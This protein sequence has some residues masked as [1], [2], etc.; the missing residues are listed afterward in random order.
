MGQITE[1]TIK[2]IREA[3]AEGR[4]PALTKWEYE[5]FCWVWENHHANPVEPPVAWR[6]WITN[7]DG[8]KSPAIRTYRMLPTDEPLYTTATQPISV[9]DQIK[10]LL[11]PFLDTGDSRT[12]EGWAVAVLVALD[13]TPNKEKG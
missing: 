3:I 1:A 2:M 13:M 9:K 7:E 5:Q 10:L 8:S 12:A 6:Y 4:P 11:R